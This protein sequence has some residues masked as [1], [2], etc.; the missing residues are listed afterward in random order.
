M[1]CPYS[2]HLTLSL[3]VHFAMPSEASFS[4][5]SDLDQTYSFTES[6]GTC[7][8]IASSPNDLHNGH[9]SSD[10]SPVQS[11][12]AST[13]TSPDSYP[14]NEDRFVHYEYVY[15]KCT[16]HIEWCVFT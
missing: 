13:H 5:P 10:V 4:D 7:F 2:L 1:V 14:H 11:S 12:R 8:S 9:V 15:G 6:Q 16:F 3:I